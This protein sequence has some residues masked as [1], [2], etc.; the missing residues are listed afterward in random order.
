MYSQPELPGKKI[1]MTYPY[2]LERNKELLYKCFVVP[3]GRKMNL[4][5]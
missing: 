1:P 4:E 2:I 3:K 5:Y